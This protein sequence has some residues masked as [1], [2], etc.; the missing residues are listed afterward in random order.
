V[1]EPLTSKIGSNVEGRGKSDAGK[2][3]NWLFIR[4]PAVFRSVVVFDL[5][6]GNP[7]ERLGFLSPL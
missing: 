2:M 5:R 1:D 3:A 7:T 4:N 6:V